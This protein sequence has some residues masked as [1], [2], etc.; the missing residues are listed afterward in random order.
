MPHLHTRPGQHDHTVSIYLF[1]TDFDEPK[2]MLHMHRKF[3]RYMQFGGHIELNETPV[4]TI[5]HEL[6][7]ESGYDIDQVQLL[8]PA[9]RLR[10][11]TGA[12]LHP[13]PLA[14]NT[15]PI[16]PDHFHTDTVYAVTTRETPRQQP[17][18]GEST[19][20]RLFTRAEVA[21]LS[22]DQT[23]DNVREIILYIFDE[24]LDTW[25]PVSPNTFG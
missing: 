8:Q 2:I 17:E 23:L 9:Q 10:A 16:P 1:R 7:E 13:V 24:I 11:L 5:V 6:K 15:H 14:Y 18:A 22:N 12:T 20:I 19:D 21:A 4:Q 3:G 25:Q